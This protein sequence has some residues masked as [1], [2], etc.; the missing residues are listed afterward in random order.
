MEPPC[1]PGECYLG[2]VLLKE[3]AAVAATVEENPRVAR[4]LAGVTLPYSREP[5]I[6][7]EEWE[8]TKLALLNAVLDTLVPGAR[9]V[10][11]AEEQTGEP[12]RVYLGRGRAFPRS[13]D[14]ATTLRQLADCLDGGK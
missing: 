2:S 5:I 4:Y 7:G 14:L 3:H 9:L 8:R 13:R 6:E 11:E 12:K 10:V 1:P